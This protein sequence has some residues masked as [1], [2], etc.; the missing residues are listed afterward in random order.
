[1]V[2]LLSHV[3]VIKRRF[4]W[5]LSVLATHSHISLQLSRIIKMFS[6]NNS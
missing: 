6:K 1:M 5:L 4:A 2:G 3:T